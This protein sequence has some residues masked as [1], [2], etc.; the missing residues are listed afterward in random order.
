MSSCKLVIK[1]EVNVKFENLSL[2][3]RKKFGRGGT[4][5]G[6]T[7]ASQLIKRENLTP[8]TVKRMFSFFSRHEVDKQ[9]QG[10][11]QGEKGY[12]SNGRIAWALWGGDA[13]FSWSKKKVKQIENESK[14]EIR[15]DVFTTPQEA[16]E[17]AKEIGC[18]GIHMHDEDGQTIYMPCETHEEYEALTGDEVKQTK[19]ESKL[20]ETAIS[21][22]TNSNGSKAN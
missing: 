4:N 9:G 14:E 15:E 3:W 6:S 10:F 17:R 8:K 20:H 5:I 18:V 22:L 1:D 11:S 2:E 19:N 21:I 16:Q 12:P 7:R 13:G